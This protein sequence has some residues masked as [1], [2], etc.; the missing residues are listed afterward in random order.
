MLIRSPAGC[1]WIVFA[2]VRLLGKNSFGVHPRWPN[3]R[4]PQ[5]NLNES[6]NDSRDD[7]L[8]ERSPKHSNDPATNQH[9]GG[10]CDEPRMIQSQS[11]RST[12]LW[13]HKSSTPAA[14]S[15]LGRL[16]RIKARCSSTSRSR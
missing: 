13:A 12:D 11:C 5:D 6:H 1:S 15:C 10:Q 3:T 8:P 9:G 2:L 14:S 7:G 4:K 16:R